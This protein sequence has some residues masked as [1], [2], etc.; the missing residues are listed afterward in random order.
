MGSTE[1][2]TD[3]VKSWRVRFACSHR[4]RDRRL[5]HGAV[6]RHG[7]ATTNGAHACDAPDAAIKVAASNGA[8]EVHGVQACH[9]AETN[10][11]VAASR[12]RPCGRR[13]AWPHG[14]WRPHGFERGLR[15][16]RVIYPGGGQAKPAGAPWLVARGDPIADRGRMLA[17][18]LAE[19]H[20]L[21]R[22]NRRSGRTPRERCPGTRQNIMAQT[23]IATN[24]R[25]TG[26]SCCEEARCRGPGELRP[27]S[28]TLVCQARAS[29]MCAEYA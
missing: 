2:T 28:T 19:A 8:A 12:R 22:D 16:R 3:R 4:K 6:A 5:Y 23:Q 21:R 27:T 17:A 11:R 7:A 29:M 10:N 18:W 20:G 14:P 26:A 9:A 13:Q 25:V 24:M 1:S 15:R